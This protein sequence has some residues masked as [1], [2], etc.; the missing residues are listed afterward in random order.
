MYRQ[1]D[2]QIDRKTDGQTNRQTGRQAGRHAGRQ[3]GRQAHMHVAFSRCVHV[4]VCSYI[5]PLSL[6]F[7]YIYVHILYQDGKRETE[8]KIR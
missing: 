3:A 2:R 6:V 1:T 8:T 7:M 4:C 5:E